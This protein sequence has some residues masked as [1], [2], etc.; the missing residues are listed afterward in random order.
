MTGSPMTKRF[1]GREGTEIQVGNTV[2]V[3]P[4][5]SGPRHPHSYALVVGRHRTNDT[6]FIRFLGYEHVHEV[7]S[8]L[9]SDP[10]E[11]LRPKTRSVNDA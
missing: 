9:L 8:N 10:V 5:V 7:A 11:M 1:I 2:Y 3:H 6:I 4:E